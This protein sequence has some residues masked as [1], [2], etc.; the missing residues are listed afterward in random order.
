MPSRHLP[1][2]LKTPSRHPPDTHQ[3]PTRDPPDTHQTPSRQFPYT[4]QIP[5]RQSPKIRHVGS[6]L[7]LKARWG[8]FLPSSCSVGK[9]SQLLLKPTE[10]ELGLQVGVEFDNIQYLFYRQSIDILS[11]LQMSLVNMF[12]TSYSYTPSIH[13]VQ[14]GIKM[15]T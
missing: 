4:L 2:T 8:L 5:T 6:F 15:F 14:P 10:V 9:Q 3:T 13:L 12:Y 7:L 1:D 11:M